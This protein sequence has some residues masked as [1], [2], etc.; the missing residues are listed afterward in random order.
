[1]TKMNQMLIKRATF[2]PPT[3]PQKKKQTSPQKVPMLPAI[4]MFMASYS[5]M[6]NFGMLL[7]VEIDHVT[8]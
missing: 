3:P 7:L 4:L 1:M 2:P 8:G 6:L 5:T